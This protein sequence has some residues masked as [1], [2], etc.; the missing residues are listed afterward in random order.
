M[1]MI[2]VSVTCSDTVSDVVNAIRK[3]SSLSSAIMS[4]R[5]L[6]SKH[7]MVLLVVLIGNVNSIEAGT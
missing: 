6:I 3:A 7:S 5:M 1:I 4:S 2:V